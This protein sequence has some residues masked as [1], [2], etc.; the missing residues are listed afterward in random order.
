MI[1][2]FNVKLWRRVPKF[3]ITIFKKYE[4]LKNNYYRVHV[5]DTLEEMWNAVDKISSEPEERN[6]NAMCKSIFK[7]YPEENKISN[8]VGYIFFAKESM[9]AGTIAHECTHAVNYYFRNFIKD[10]KKL[11]SDS[12]YDET[13]AYMLGSLVWQINHFMWD[14]NLYDD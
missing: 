10:N 1:Y 3:E 5:C 4:K 12:T 14:N 13:F 7:I 2:K 11:F 6:Y 8:R 9:G